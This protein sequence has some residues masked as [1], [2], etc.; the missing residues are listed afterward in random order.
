MVCSQLPPL[1]CILCSSICAG[2]HGWIFDTYHTRYATLVSPYFFPGFGLPVL[3]A[4][5]TPERIS[6]TEY[7]FGEILCLTLAWLCHLPAWCLSPFLSAFL[8]SRRA[9]EIDRTLKK[10]DEGVALFDEIWDK[11]YSATQQNQ[12]EK[13]EGDLKKE[14]KKLQ[15]G[16]MELLYCTTLQAVSSNKVML[17]FLKSRGH[18]Q[19]RH[20]SHVTFH[21]GCASHHIL[22][23][24]STRGTK[25]NTAG[26]WPLDTAVV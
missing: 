17:A 7:P 18:Q 11:V 21:G 8:D 10:V 24:A 25:P 5:V 3:S 1:L 26:R 20:T 13:Y 14:I 23:L 22:A 16:V 2:Y 19:T 12:K 9:A 6:Y 15:V 4:E